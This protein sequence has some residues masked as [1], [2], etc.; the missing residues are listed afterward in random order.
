MWI[1]YALSASLMWGLTYVV[2]EQVY[3]KISVVTSLAITTLATGVVMLLIA[4]SG[5]FLQK[6]LN[7]ISNSRKLLYLIIAETILLILA[8]LF[9]GLSIT[10]KNATLAG[11][12]EI[13]YPIFIVL[14]A[15][16]LFKEN[17]LNASTA[18]GGAFIFVGVFVIYYFNK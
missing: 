1:I 2:N 11:L 5:N 4:Y 10:S 12:I 13:S 8:E 7:V 9:I 17:Q 6:D 3:K 18:V 15:Y 14:F 16:L